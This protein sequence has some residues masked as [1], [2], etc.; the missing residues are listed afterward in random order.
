MPGLRFGR[1]ML[2]WRT[3]FLRERDWQL[4]NVLWPV[5]AYGL[6]A[7]WDLSSADGMVPLLPIFVMNSAVAKTGET[8]RRKDDSWRPRL[9]VWNLIVLS[10]LF[11]LAM[12]AGIGGTDRFGPPGMLV[13]FL[14]PMALLFLPWPL[15]NP[16][17]NGLKLGFIES[18]KISIALTNG[19]GRA[20]RQ[21]L[22]LAILAGTAVFAVPLVWALPHVLPSDWP[23]PAW[24]PGLLWCMLA[25]PASMLTAAMATALYIELGGTKAAPEREE[26]VETFG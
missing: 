2:R 26:M 22:A 17:Q 6:G 18:L 14:V 24:L 19:R 21:Y 8:A 11:L 16:A 15:A 3:E 20:V 25:A 10:L 9:L 13:E 5:A 4:A 7:L 23:R 12:V 1:V